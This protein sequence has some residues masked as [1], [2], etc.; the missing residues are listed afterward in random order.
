MASEARWMPSKTNVRLALVQV[1]VPW[2]P[3]II[4]DA[5]NGW[6]LRASAFPVVYDQSWLSAHC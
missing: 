6:G 5:W 2:M 4:S 3:M 1:M